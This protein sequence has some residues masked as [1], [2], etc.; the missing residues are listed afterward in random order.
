MIGESV[1]RDIIAGK[2]FI[3]LT[4]GP[5]DLDIVF[6]PDGI[7]SYA[8]AKRRQSPRESFRWPTSVTSSPARGRAAA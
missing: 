8:A 1:D 4:N 7:E 5:F 3:Q 2:D 6:A